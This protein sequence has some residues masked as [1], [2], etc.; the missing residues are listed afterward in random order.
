M[1]SLPLVNNFTS[2]LDIFNQATNE[3]ISS[4]VNDPPQNVV[5]ERSKDNLLRPVRGLT[6]AYP[7][8]PLTVQRLVHSDSV[9]NAYMPLFTVMQIVC[10][11]YLVNYNIHK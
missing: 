11:Q 7:I 3:P 9:I 2:N 8:K 1:L 4:E 10:E 5:F 6:G